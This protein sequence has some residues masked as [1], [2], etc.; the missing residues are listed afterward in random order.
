MS[1]RVRYPPSPTGLQ[2]IGGVRTALFNYFFARANGGTFILRIEDTDRTRSTEDAVQDLYDTLSWLGLEWD[3]G[4]DKGGNYGPYIQSQRTALYTEYAAKL[5][6]SGHA[7][8]CFCST[9][10]IESLRK[11]QEE[12]KLRTGYDG[13]CRNLS[14][15]M[16]AGYES[17]NVPHVV[18]F[19]VPDRGKTAFYDILLGEISS[20]NEDIPQDPILM[21]SDGFPTYHLANVVDDHLMEITHILRA[22]EW[23]PSVPLHVL[24]YDAFGWSPPVF[25]H[26][27]L[28]LGKDGQKLSKR[29]GSTAVKDYR[30]AGY[31]P[32][33]VI[34]YLTLVGWS[35]DDK[36]EFFSKQ[37]L[38][39]LF[40]LDKLN[41]APG[42]FDVKK[43]EWFNGQYIRL[44][45]DEEL[46]DLI[47]PFLQKEL[48]SDPM[49]ESEQHVV[50]GML[51]LVKER[52]RLLPEVTEMVRFLF[53]EINEYSI[54]DIV[55]K[56]LDSDKT[57]E[58]LKKGR[59]ILEE[60]AE[61]SD[62]QNERAFTEAAEEINVK[63]G[64]M[65]MPIRV[66]VTGTPA[67]PPL[68]GSM[69]LLDPEIILKRIDRA[70]SLL[71]GGK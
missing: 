56:K 45:S 69:R 14:P 24:L 39:E 61:K 50:D 13:H 4:P 38:E 70:V 26:L 10:R 11:E 64:S 9:E 71:E 58:I 51:P 7:Y 34:N 44:K 27:P 46:L 5:I 60:F 42:V 62:E 6:A 32:E 19:R 20:R 25:C 54:E 8:K 15:E 40:T 57:V 48:V 16:I 28:V 21:K 43:L 52:L 35:Y 59:A 36:R 17:G 65:L 55:P 1:V 29:H 31:L 3:E 41:K 47:L 37:E 33:A 66:A 67:S 53:K 49:T 2:H 12:K 30:E 18:R 68:F 23:L 63:L 22:Q